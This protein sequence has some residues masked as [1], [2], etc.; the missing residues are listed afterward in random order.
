MRGTRC[1][2]LWNKHTRQD[3]NALTVPKKWMLQSYVYNGKERITKGQGAWVAFGPNNS[4]GSFNGVNSTGHPA[5]EPAYEATADG[6]FR[7]ITENQITTAVGIANIGALPRPTSVGRAS[8][9]GVNC[10]GGHGL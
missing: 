3:P 4:F 5:G 6:G 2:G 9:V 7:M 8:T 1:A 10:Y